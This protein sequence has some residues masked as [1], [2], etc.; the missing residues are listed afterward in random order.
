LPDPLRVA[1]VGLVQVG[2][3]GFD[4]KISKLPYVRPSFVGAK[5]TAI[6]QLSP[7]SNSGPQSLVWEKS[8]VI[9]GGDT[10]P[11]EL[12]RFTTVIV[13]GLL[14]VPTRWFL[15]INFTGVM[16]R[17]DSRSLEKQGACDGVVCCCV[18]GAVVF[19]VS[20]HAA[21][22]ARIHPRPTTAAILPRI[23]TD[24]LSLR[25]FS[26]SQI[27]ITPKGQAPARS[28]LPRVRCPLTPNPTPVSTSATN[29]LMAPQNGF[30]L[31]QGVVGTPLLARSCDGFSMVDGLSI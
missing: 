24:L 6:L 19:A 26:A 16:V 17:G 22:S 13:C 1:V 29:R 8:P 25:P 28:H 3:S 2:V 30:S 23:R 20:I 12:P 18:S 9:F 4:D 31:C 27:A 11:R 10:I 14:V 21:P 15:K 5:V 7:I